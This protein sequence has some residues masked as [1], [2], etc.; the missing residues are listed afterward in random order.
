MVLAVVLLHQGSR[1]LFTGLS[2]DKLR[3]CPGLDP[4]TNR[5]GLRVN[6]LEVR[7]SGLLSGDSGFR[8]SAGTT[9]WEEMVGHR[10]LE[11]RTSVLSGLRSNRLS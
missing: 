2:F 1:G 8:L 3:A 10:G 5:Y 9:G 7:S 4:G 6:G 11:P